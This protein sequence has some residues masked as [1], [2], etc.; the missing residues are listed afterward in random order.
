VRTLI[1]IAALTACSYHGTQLPRRNSVGEVE[2]SD[3]IGVPIFDTVV[4][5]AALGFAA[6]VYNDLHGD[7]STRDDAYKVA[8]PI[9]FLSALGFSSAV[10]GFRN[11]PR[12]RKAIAQ[13][14]E[15]VKIVR[16]RRRELKKVRAD[17]WAITKKAAA[18]ARAGDCATVV[19][20]D[21]QLRV[22]DEE[23]YRVVFLGD[24]AIVRCLPQPEKPPAAVP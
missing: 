18:A 6:Y 10:Y 24:V 9:L 19:T 7:R 22:I 1:A 2:C 23:F 3:D 21:A 17:A 4:G 20:L 15:N 8:G 12:C 11:V 5:F 13:E 16:Q 14:R